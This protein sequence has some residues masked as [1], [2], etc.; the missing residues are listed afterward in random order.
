MMDST[1]G[2]MRLYRCVAGAV[3]RQEEEEEKDDNFPLI[4][5]YATAYHRERMRE[6]KAAAGYRN[7]LYEDAD[8]IHVTQAGKEALD[9]LGLIRDGELGFL[10]V[11]ASADRVIYNGPKDYVFGGKIVLCG[12]NRKAHC[13][14]RGLWHQTKFLGLQSLL[15]S[16]APD[17]PVSIDEECERP[18]HPIRGRVAKDGWVYPLE[19]T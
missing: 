18:F 9:K 6:L 8:S 4:A 14:P 7:T 19:E 3:F 17:G 1:T 16:S 15:S 12:L 13:D 10:R 2:Q 5:A 11:E